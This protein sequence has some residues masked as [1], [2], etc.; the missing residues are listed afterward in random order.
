MTDTALP[1]REDLQALKREGI[2]FQAPVSVRAVSLAAI[3]GA[4]IS[5]WPGNS[6]DF[7]LLVPESLIQLK[8]MCEGAA[9]FSI[10]LTGAALAATLMVVLI[11]NGFT[12]SASLLGPQAGKMLKPSILRSTGSLAL[13]AAFG[14]GLGYLFAGDLFLLSRSTD[15]PSLAAALGTIGAALAKVAIGGLIA[16]AL[17]SAASARLAFLLR[18][19]VKRGSS[20]Q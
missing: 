4:A 15:Q 11:F 14:C 3:V 17:V 12:L 19:R 10:V 6:G 20:E 18:H 5:A 16:I 7:R 13:G 1:T 9:I 2:V 8:Q